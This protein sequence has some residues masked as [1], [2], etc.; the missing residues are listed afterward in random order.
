[1]TKNE[2]GES[3]MNFAQAFFA[4]VVGGAMMNVLEVVT[5]T[6]NAA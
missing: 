5:S 3:A 6:K 2:N 4:G 1:M